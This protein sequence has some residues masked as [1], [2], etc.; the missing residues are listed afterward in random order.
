MIVRKLTGA[1]LLLSLGATVFL[2]WGSSEA[3][4]HIRKPELNKQEAQPNI[5][6]LFA[7]A[8]GGSYALDMNGAAWIWL[9]L[10]PDTTES[11]QAA[12]VIIRYRPKA[13]GGA[14][15]APYGAVLKHYYL[16]PKLGQVQQLGET[17]VYRDGRA[18]QAVRRPYDAAH[19]FTPEKGSPEAKILEY[20]P[21][22][23]DPEYAGREMALSTVDEVRQ[24]AAQAR[25]ALWAE[26]AAQGR[27]PKLYLH[28]TAEHYGRF[29]C[30]YHINIDQ[31]GAIY[32]ST[33]DF[34]QYVPGTWLRNHGAVNLTLCGAVGSS[35]KSLGPEPPTEAQI[36]TMAR[37]IAA[38]SDGI[39]IPIDKQHV[40]THGEAA[41]NEDGLQNHQPYPWWNDSYGDKD[42]RGDLE[43]LGTEES[44]S[45]APGDP[46]KQAQRGG[47][48]LR[49][50]ALAYQAAEK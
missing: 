38:L 7:D 39:G 31:D 19:W 23:L 21:A 26:A 37:V 15:R 29:F 50:K 24:L 46:G 8:E 12:S 32:L 36:E 17:P 10:S 5:R 27:E 2:P 22:Y 4:V 14:N 35:P 48:V 13:A 9:R 3:Y 43:Y 45:Y 41:N 28:W 11:V 6:P 18:A 47:S 34:A 42:T 1:V 40:L 33:K 44:P 30:S 20:A 49:A 25:E 16:C